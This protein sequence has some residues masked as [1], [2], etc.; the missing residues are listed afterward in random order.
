MLQGWTDVQSGK[1]W[2]K[3]WLGKEAREG[4][5][6]VEACKEASDMVIVIGRHGLRH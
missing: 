2:W 3:A 1:I 6:P 5:L 4:H